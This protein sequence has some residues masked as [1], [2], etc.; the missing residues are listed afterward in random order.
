MALQAD[1]WSALLR[2]GRRTV[3]QLDLWP[4]SS[5]VN[6]QEASRVIYQSFLL[7]VKNVLESVSLTFSLRE[8]SLYPPCI[9]PWQMRRAKNPGEKTVNFPFIFREAVGN[10]FLQNRNCIFPHGYQAHGQE[11]CAWVTNKSIWMNKWGHEVQA[12]WKHELNLAE[13]LKHDWH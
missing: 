1:T 9:L 6:S 4:K 7:S 2:T 11:H 8:S 3:F 12:K 10:R 5:P 13:S